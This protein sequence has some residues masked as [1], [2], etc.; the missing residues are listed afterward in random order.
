MLGLG[1]VPDEVIDAFAVCE[2]LPSEEAPGKLRPLCMSAYPR[3]TAMR[4]IV[5]LCKDEIMS[6]CGPDQVAIGVSDGCA[7]IYQAIQAQCRL[8]PSKVVLQEDV[9]K[10]HQSLER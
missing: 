9:K 8:Q 10:A 4:A 3:R 1:R 5:R 6:A 7:K 2:V